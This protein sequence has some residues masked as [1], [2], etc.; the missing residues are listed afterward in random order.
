MN[1]DENQDRPGASGDSSQLREL[2]REHRRPEALSDEHARELDVLQALGLAVSASLALEQTSAA[3]LEGMIRAMEPDLAFLFLRQDDRLILQEMLPTEARQRL[4]AIPEHR[5]GE[6]LCGLA[7]RE[8]RPI[9]SRD[10]HS[11]PRC[12]WEECRQAGFRSFAALPLRSGTEIIGVMGLAA[13]TERDFEARAGF[14]ETLAHQV[15][16]ALANARLFQ[17][18]RRE[19]AER[20]RAEEKL[21]ASEERYRRLADNAPDAIYRM[22]LPDGTYRYVSPAATTIFGYSPEEF[23]ANPQLALKILHPDWIPYFKE[24]W[25]RLLRGDVPPTYEY[26]II[27]KNGAIRWVNQRNVLLT[28]ADGRPS[29]IEGIVTDVTDQKRGETALRESEEKYR[30]LIETTGTGYVILDDHGRVTDANQEY[31]QLTG[32]PGVEDIIGRSVLEWTAP[33]DLERNAA[34]VQKCLEQ[35]F[36][37]HLEIDYLTP[38]GR[39]IPVEI[40][41]TVLRS[42]GVLRILTLC[43]D[44]TERKRTEETIRRNEELLRSLIDSAPFGAHLYEL[45]EHDRLVFSGY[46]R[47]AN[48][49]LGVDNDQFLGQT[50]EEAFPPLVETEIPARY[51]RA[52]AAGEGFEIEQVAY[53]HGKIRGAFEVHAFQTAPRKMAAF[54]VD[55]TERK[56]AESRLLRSE[57][58]LR[59]ALQAANQGLYDLNVQT[60]EAQISPE[61]ATMLGYDPAEFHE[62]NAAWIER[63][64]PED[65][66]PMAA[67]YRDYVAGQIPDYRVEFRQRTQSGDWKWILSLGKIVERD[68]RGEPLRMLGTHTDITQRKRAEEAL[69]ESEARYRAL[70]EANPHPMWVYDLETLAFLT[71]NDAAVAHYGF[72]RDEFLAMTIADIRPTEDVPRLLEN[73]ARVG[74]RGFDKTDIWKHRRKDGSTIQVEITSHFLDYQGRRARLV[75]ANDITER[76]QAEEE[77]EKLQAQLLQAQKMESVGR[78]A[79]GV[80]HD[81]NNMLSAILGYAELAMMQS[82]PIGSDLCRPGSHPES[83]PAFRRPHPSTAGLC[84]QTDRGAQGPGSERHRG[85]HAQDAAA[86]DRRG[87]RSG[88]DAGSGPV[89]GQDGPLPDRPDSGE[90]LRQRP[91]AIAGV[92][93]VTIETENIAFD[94]AHCAVHPGQA[95]G[96]YVLLVVSDDGCGMSPEVLDHLFEPFFT[97]KEVGKGTG[98]GLATVYGIVQQNE[99]FINVYSEPGRG[100]TFKIYLPRFVG[101]APEPTA[102]SLAEAPRGRGETVLLVEDEAAIL[103]MG[104]AMLEGLGYTVLTADTPGEALRQARARA[105]QIQLLI[106]DVVMPEMNGR[107]LAKLIR[108]IKPGV[109]C[110]FTSGYTTEII[111]HRGVLEEGVYFLQKPFSRKDLASMVRQ[112]LGGERGRNG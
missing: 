17:A 103:H 20:K 95:C 112:A 24:Q 15:S 68:A 6:C 26:Q 14:L 73:V 106:T 2:Q 51:K 80:A 5:V 92:G 21:Q 93:Q 38:N 4:G 78:L 102:E 111:A 58:R 99:G 35:G 87:H 83:R 49:I 98:L 89:A 62:T 75:L 22:S 82:R 61:Y 7:V 72:S 67:I 65:R 16:V 19:V 13:M 109:K 54:F 25:D 97:T 31:A 64:H 74:E 76:Q 57:E 23:Y 33:H 71:V 42:S 45:D 107:E 50:I 27:H 34:E 105:A 43:R 30:R 96:E 63:L 32:R 29:D 48:R 66:E 39:I 46:N 100:T 110:L 70:F 28:G 52:A 36:A 79:G 1:D 60:G 108:D 77:K 85:G 69:Q 90:S 53:E 56:R 101:Q 81:F 12:T 37:R 104:R 94:E 84:P 88:L 3:A 91:D 55:I 40:N 59:L 86:A 47:S 18:A 8:D 9:Y 44:I 10:I 11:D 41:A